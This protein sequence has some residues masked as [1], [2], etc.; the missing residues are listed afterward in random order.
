MVEAVQGEGDAC[1][2]RVAGDVGERFLDDAEDGGAGRVVEAQL[3]F[4]GQQGA[5]DAVALDE[6]VAQSLQGEKQPAFVEGARAQVGGD[7]AQRSNGGEQV[8]V[9][10][11]DQVQRLRGVAAG[12]VQQGQVHAQRG[13]QLAE[14]VV[15]FARDVGALLLADGLQRGG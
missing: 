2:L 8:A 1:R 13:E 4:V 12:F 14:V 10:A 6:I 9:H 7:A 5:G 11:L 3:G 15:Q